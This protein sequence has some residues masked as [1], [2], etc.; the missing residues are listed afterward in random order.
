MMVKSEF[1]QLLKFLL[2]IDKIHMVKILYLLCEINM[3]IYHIISRNIHVN[4]FRQ[5][6][7]AKK[8]V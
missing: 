4:K 7:W 5:V 2:R 8:K 3:L 6:K 1:V